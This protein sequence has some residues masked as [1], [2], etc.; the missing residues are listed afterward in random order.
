[1]SVFQGMRRSVLPA[2]AR[3]VRRPGVE[4]ALRGG[5]IVCAALALVLALATRS[6]ARSPGDAQRFSGHTAPH[7]ALPAVQ[8][9]GLLP[10]PLALTGQ[11]GRPTLLLF[12]YSLC[13]PCLGE[14]RAVQQLQRT[15][16]AR[17]L[18]VVYIDSPAEATRI[19]A[20]YQQ[21]LDMRDPMLLDAHG[22]VAERMGIH[23]YPATA[24]VDTRGVIRQVVTGE[25]S[26]QTLQREIEAVLR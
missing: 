22:N 1:M 20:A 2:L 18:H 12:T 11:Q 17:G 13:P 10:T 19:V 26:L 25:E 8:D 15:Y 16:A 6:L 21:R 7:V 5:V 9:G 24:L 4:A 14:I 23:Y 3:F